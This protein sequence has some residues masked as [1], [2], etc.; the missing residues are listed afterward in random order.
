M[1]EAF[2]VFANYGQ[3]VPLI[4]IL[5]VEDWKGN[6]LEETKPEENKGEEVLS[7]QV[8]FLISHILEDNNARSAAFGSYSQLV[9]RG[10]PEVSVKT[11]TTNNLRDNWTIGYTADTLV[12]VWV[13]NNDNSPMS[14]AVSGVSGASPIWNKV[15]KYA[16]DNNDNEDPD[17]LKRPEEI[18]EADVCVTSGIVPPADGFEA[19]CPTRHEYFLEGTIPTQIKGGLQDVRYDNRTGLFA[20]ENTPPEE[21]HVEQHNLIFDPLDTFICFDCNVQASSQSATVNYSTISTKETEQSP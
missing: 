17:W 19:G 21:T 15:M 7:P 9:V 3:K 2:G 1:A 14:G 18:V 5:K 11:G 13:G 20:D 16:L 8:S 12:V 4:S 10:H 6:V